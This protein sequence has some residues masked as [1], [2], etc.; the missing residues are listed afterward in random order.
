[1]TASPNPEPAHLD[2]GMRIKKADHPLTAELMYPDGYVPKRF[3]RKMSG[4]TR[5]L[6]PF[7]KGTWGVWCVRDGGPQEILKDDR[8][9][10]SVK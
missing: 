6:R 1:M 9:D 5:Y 7:W 3:V 8:G 4:H 10:W 2:A